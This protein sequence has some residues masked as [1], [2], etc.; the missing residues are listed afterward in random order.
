MIT[1]RKAGVI[2]AADKGEYDDEISLKYKETGKE[3]QWTP[4]STVPKQV[5]KSWIKKQQHL[6]WLRIQGLTKGDNNEIRVDYRRD[7][8][9]H[10]R[11]QVSN[12]VSAMEVPTGVFNK[13]AAKLNVN[14]V[15]AHGSSGEDIFI[16]S[17]TAWD[18]LLESSDEEGSSQVPMVEATSGTD[19][20]ADY[21]Y[22][23][24]DAPSNPHFPLP[25][26]I[27]GTCDDTDKPLDDFTHTIHVAPCQSGKH[28]PSEPYYTC[29]GCHQKDPVYRLTKHEQNH[30]I[31]DK[32]L[33]RLCNTCAEVAI[34]N[35]SINTEEG[36]DV[37]RCLCNQ[38]LPQWLCV[39]CW[40]E[41]AKMRSR[42]RDGTSKCGC[43]R[44]D[45]RKAKPKNRRFGLS[46]TVRVVMNWSSGR[47]ERV[48]G[49]LSFLIGLF[50]VAG[51]D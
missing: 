3:A 22:D 51:H 47:F 20:E 36:Q 29:T 41:M 44:Q 37:N 13:W 43:G 45:S 32:G 46:T 2:E 35:H 33:F 8:K 7:D 30:M 9:K 48:T 19:N 16:L 34:Q 17:D 6:P 49:S 5:V 50:E 4:I 42:K 27:H 25:T 1:G 18:L 39:E 40:V 15:L 24:E 12:W 10:V 31:R 26:T 28:H 14:P 11:R 23:I 21:I 38:G